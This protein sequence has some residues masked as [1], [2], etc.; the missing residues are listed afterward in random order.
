MRVY[1][2]STSRPLPA[3]KLVDL[4]HEPKTPGKHG[5]IGPTL[6][7]AMTRVLANDFEV[8][9]L[10]DGVEKSLGRLVSARCG[11]SAAIVAMMVNI[12]AGLF[13]K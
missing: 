11:E 2:A 5:A 9:V 7:D 12:A 13:Q 8:L 6:E 3:V 4:R 10:T 1:G